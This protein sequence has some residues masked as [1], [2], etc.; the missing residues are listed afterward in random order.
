MTHIE[1]L[2]TG[3]IQDTNEELSFNGLSVQG[4]VTT[5]NQPTELT[6]IDGLSQTRNSPA[7]LFQVLTL[8]DPFITFNFK[9]LIKDYFR[10]Y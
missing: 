4:L 7:D 9:F 1:N 10:S 6:S 2:E 3:N 8:V 5:L